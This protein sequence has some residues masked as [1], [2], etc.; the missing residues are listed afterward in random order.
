MCSVQDLEEEFDTPLSL[1][2]FAQF[3]ELQIT[4]ANASLHTEFDSW[5]YSW[6]SSS[7]SSMEMYKHLKGA[8]SNNVI[9]KWLWK[10]AS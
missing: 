8:Q 3:N 2:A 1:Q 4:I 9:F 7:Y 5:S 6:N 10:C